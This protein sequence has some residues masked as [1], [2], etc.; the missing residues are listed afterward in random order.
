MTNSKRTATRLLHLKLDARFMDAMDKMRGDT[1]SETSIIVDSIEQYVSEFERRPSSLPP[2][3][4]Q[5]EYPD[6]MHDKVLSVDIELFRRL[7]EIRNR[8]P[9]KE[10]PFYNQLVNLAVYKRLA[11]AKLI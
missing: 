2:V 4:E 8:R 9:R 5:T 11:S 10:R 7:V 1:Q 3:K 6:G